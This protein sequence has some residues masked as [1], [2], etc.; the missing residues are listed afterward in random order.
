M[1]VTTLL[2]HPINLPFS[3]HDQVLFFNLKYHLTNATS[4]ANSISVES[5]PFPFLGCRF[6]L[7]LSVRGI[8]IRSCPSLGSGLEWV[9]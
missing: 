8:S 7:L 5:I 1:Y 2:V 6:G 9:F 4:M 3:V